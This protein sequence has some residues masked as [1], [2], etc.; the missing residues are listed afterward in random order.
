LEKKIINYKNQD[1]NTNRDYD[2]KEYIDVK[3]I[4]QKYKEQRCCCKYCGVEMELNNNENDNCL[5]VD[6]INSDD[7]AHTKNNCQLLCVHCNKTKGD[8]F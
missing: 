2:E 3:W 5:T 6:R 7:M 1:K 4:L 8:R